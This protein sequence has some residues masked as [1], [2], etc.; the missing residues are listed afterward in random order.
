MYESIPN[1]MS[2]K[3]V[4]C[5]LG[6][7]KGTIYEEIKRGRMRSIKVGRKYIVPKHCLLEYLNGVLLVPTT[8]D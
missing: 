6:V 3:D 2:V 8:A 7:G 4:S 5:I 1:I